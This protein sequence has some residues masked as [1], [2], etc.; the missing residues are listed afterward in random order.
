MK[1]MQQGFTLIELMIVVAIIGIL[2]AVALPQYQNYTNKSKIGAC[3]AEAV[4]VIRGAVAATAN[5]DV[6]MMPSY[7]PG[8]K[9]AC[10]SS[11]YSSTALLPSGNTTFTSKDTAATVIT[12]VNATG[13]CTKP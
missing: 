3:Q 5:D 12:C 2:A 4:G 9:A 8:A 1:K 11:T 13:N 6:S 10:A 7:T